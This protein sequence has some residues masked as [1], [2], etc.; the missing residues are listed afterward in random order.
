M[1]LATEGLIGRICREEDADVASGVEV[2][3]GWDRAFLSEIHEG[4]ALP[5][6]LST[7]I[8]SRS[9]VRCM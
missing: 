4:V 2:L 9:L 1:A 7:A 5:C 6:R 8:N 3:G